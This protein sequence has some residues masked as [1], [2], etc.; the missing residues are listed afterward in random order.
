MHP[1][2]NALLLQVACESFQRKLLPIEASTT[3][4][5]PAVIP[6]DL[7]LLGMHAG[8]VDDLWSW[9]Y[10][11]V[12]LWEGKLPWRRDHATKESP[13]DKEA[14]LELKLHC[15]QEPAELTPASALPGVY[16]SRAVRLLVNATAC[17]L[18]L[19]CSLDR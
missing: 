4:V 10:L 19:M 2:H 7:I 1:Q 5:L 12:E 8:R 17:K 6:A 11:L 9:F 14:I 13:P 3:W 18:S 15:Q 16:V